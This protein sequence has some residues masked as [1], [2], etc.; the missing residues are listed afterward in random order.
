LGV[1]LGNRWLEN[2]TISDDDIEYL[3]GILLEKEI[4]LSIDELALALIER[5]IKKQESALKAVVKDVRIYAP[6]H[7]YEIGQRLMF[8]AFDNRIGTVVDLRDGDNPA[9]GDFSVLRVQFEDGGAPREFAAQLRLDHPLNH[10][11]SAV[12]I[13]QLPSAAQVFEINKAQICARLAEKLGQL[14]EFVSVA[15]KWFPRSLMLEVN[16]G[17]LNLAEAVLD[18]A[19][20]EPMR[21]SDILEQIG[22]LG[23]A[24]LALQ[25]FC[26]D[27]ALNRD[28]RFDEVG[29][30]D[31]ILWYLRRLEPPE[32]QSTPPMLEYQPVTFDR[33][34]LSPEL[35]ALEAEIDDEWS[36][37]D[38]TDDPNPAGEASILLIYP[39]RRVGT[40]PL[41]HGMRRIFPTARRTPRVYVKLVDAEDGEEFTGW[42]VRQ[43]R[44][45]F[46]LSKFYRKHQVPVGAR[47]I[48]RRSSEPGKIIIEV[49]NYRKRA[50]WVRLIVPRDGQIKFE[51]QKRS[52]SAEYD[53]QMILGTDDIAAVDALFQ[54]TSS[55]RKSIS[56]ILRTLIAELMTSSPQ[57][58]VH[59][60]TLYSAFNV[61]RRCP[62]GPIFAAL[63]T[64]GD[65][66]H[67]GSHYWK[68]RESARKD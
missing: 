28:P 38:H 49:K 64:T 2:W 1:A 33:T 65:F 5:R 8:T 45:V 32:V 37:I 34:L 51:E 4:P 61:L 40:L 29:P 60:K 12:P 17:H 26:L 59:A 36:D 67:I 47:I 57:G 13:E 7:S 66:E 20:G 22:G 6:A 31:T 55:S 63:M 43:S 48:A 21:T 19:G 68:L 46:G 10:V 62:P 53:D 54:A 27:D 9:Y 18:I 3:N 50:E 23:K 14:D 41:N 11:D 15:G 58:A 44:Y 39:H 16:E 56:S 30:V 35:M 52:L 25:T 42:V 24:D